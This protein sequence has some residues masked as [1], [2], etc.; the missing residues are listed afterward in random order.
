MI[1]DDMTTMK[2][3][4]RVLIADDD[5]VLRSLVIANLQGRADEVT[6][7]ADGLLAWDLLLSRQFELALID[8]SM[9]NLDGFTLIQCMRSHQRTKHMPIIVI[10]SNNDQA[11]IER[12]FQAGASSFLTKPLNWP[13]FG[14]HVDYLT[15]LSDGGHCA[16]ASTRQAEA[17]ARAKDAVIATLAARINQHTNRI[18]AAAQDELRPRTADADV[19]AAFNLARSVLAEAIAISEVCEETLP[20]LRG[21]TEQIVTDDRP[22]PLARLLD[23]GVRH[24]TRLALSRQVRIALGRVDDAAIVKCDDKAV[25]RA[26]ASLIRNAVQHSA[27]G[28]AVNVTAERRDD[29]VLVISVVDQG[30]GADPAHIAACLRPL[31]RLAI[32]AATTDERVGLGLPIAM[33]I[34]RAHGG[35]LEVSTAPGQGTTAA[36][37]LPAEVVEVRRDDTA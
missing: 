12:A 35:S 5:P 1:V 27:A 19:V 37:I 36:L 33:A 6:E 31:D 20:H 25:G 11:S 30:V 18:I 23:E 10:T 14:H 34:A 9:P 17:V 29:N 21:I 7:A 13:L 4:V 22:V 32:P 8:L 16:R 28:S 24:V 2:P 15:R 26:L 3:H